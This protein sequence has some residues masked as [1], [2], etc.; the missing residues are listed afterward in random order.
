M[1]FKFLLFLILPLSLS[2][3]QIKGTVYDAV[4][5]EA[6]ES[7]NVYF[8]GTSKG[9]ITDFDGNFEIPYYVNTQSTFTISLL[10]YVS[11]SFKDPLHTDFSNIRLQPKVGEL[12]AVFL[13]PDPWSREKK[14]K[15]FV[16]QFLGT[17]L[18]AKQCSI[19]NLDKIKMRFNPST[20]K[21][22]AFAQEPIRIENRDLNYL[23]TYD[24]TDFEITFESISLENV[25]IMGDFEAPTHRMVSSFFVGS[26]FFKE[27]DE[28]KANKGWVKRHRRRAYKVSE[29]RLFKLMASGEFEKEGYKL[30]FKRKKVDFDNH[31]RSRKHGNS[32][33]LD[34]RES[35][36]D[37]MDS[38]NF[39][40]AI[41]LEEPKLIVS[42]PGNVINYHVLKIGGF[43]SYLKVS[44]MLP[45]DY[46]LK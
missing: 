21:M 20:G 13:N 9:T 17:T 18:I 39:Q 36:Y 5:H 24:L 45:L 16:K 30:F 22:I 11:Q 7:V 33:I 34:F 12:P 28:S 38:K 26:A 37:I 14:E 8:S 29:V 46:E 10:G 2:A 32:Y 44:G 15:Y 40:S 25:Q 19:L 4:T 35:Q 41:Y 6:L 42:E 27:L 3:Q 43:I 1:T 23:V 31:I